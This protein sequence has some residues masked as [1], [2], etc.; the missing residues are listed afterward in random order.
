[1]KWY[2]LWIL[3]L[4]GTFL[5]AV[6]FGGEGPGKIG[7]VKGTITIGGR[8]T[9]EAV[10]SVEGLSREKLE[11]QNSK[12]KTGKAV[13]DQQDLKFLPH[14]LPVLVGTAVEFSNNDKTFHNVFSTS[15]AKKFDLGLYSP[16][17][18]R[19]VTFDKPGV[20]RILCHVHPNMEAYVVVK[21]HPYYAATDARGNYSLG[22]IPL[23]KYR[24]EV[25]H[26]ETGAK[27]VPFELVRDG[28]V[29]TLDVEMKSQR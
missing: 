11:T 24:L 25:W 21:S 7:I 3:S 16:G 28:E 8:A 9:S 27:Q 12:L 6:T 20:V 23:G 1:M 15:E 4:V 5:P 10:V 13:M 14:V 26:P 2:H 17:R 18:R 22:G 29:L 19:S